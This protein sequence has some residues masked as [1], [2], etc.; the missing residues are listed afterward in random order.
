MIINVFNFAITIKKMSN[1][2]L[3]FEALEA[4]RVNRAMESVKDKYFY[5]GL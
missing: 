2:D 4:D 1:R 5:P 3:C